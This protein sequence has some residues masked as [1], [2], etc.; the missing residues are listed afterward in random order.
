MFVLE[1]VSKYM[2]R[3]FRSTTCTE[4]E[5]RAMKITSSL[6]SRERAHTFRAYTAQ[7]VSNSDWSNSSVIFAETDKFRAEE[8]RS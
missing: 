6:V 4:A 5:L 8:K 1:Q 2:C 7:R 3:D